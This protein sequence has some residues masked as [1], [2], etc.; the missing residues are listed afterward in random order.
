MMINLSTEEIINNAIVILCVI[1]TLNIVLKMKKVKREIKDEEKRED[2][3]TTLR[4]AL[5][6]EV[7]CVAM[8]IINLIV[9]KSIVIPFGVLILAFTMQYDKILNILCDEA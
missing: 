4:F 7:I 3:N 5:F 9:W 1:A 6:I 2:W 8:V